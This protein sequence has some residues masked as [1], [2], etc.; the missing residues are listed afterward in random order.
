MDKPIKIKQGWQWRVY[1]YHRFVIKKRL[2]Y[3]ETRKAVKYWHHLEHAGKKEIGSHTKKVIADVVYALSAIKRSKIPSS[4]LADLTFLPG[5]SI[6]Q[7]RAVTLAVRFRNLMKKK[8]IRE[9]KLL[10]DNFITLNLELWKYGIF[11][12]IFKFH[13]NNGVI[14][15]HVALLDPFELL[16]RP[17]DIEK[18]LQ[19]KPWEHYIRSFHFPKS[20]RTYFLRSCNKAFRPAYFRKVWRS[21]RHRRALNKKER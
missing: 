16:Y 15:K 5:G 3:D 12:R 7:R 13:R 10:I 8:K 18:R 17:S 20:V 21:M 9:M 1:F 14:G 4:L 6:R 11:E 19:K 2:S